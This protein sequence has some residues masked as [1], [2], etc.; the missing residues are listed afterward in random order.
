M[1]L[2]EFEQGGT[3]ALLGVFQRILDEEIVLGSM[4]YAFFA[5]LAQYARMSVSLFQPSLI[6]GAWVPQGNTY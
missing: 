6:F 2:E 5:V 1:I 3:Q 4:L